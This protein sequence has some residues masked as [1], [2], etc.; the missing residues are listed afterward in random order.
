MELDPSIL[1]PVRD[2]QKYVRNI[3]AVRQ[4][5]TLDRAARH[6]LGDMV[7]A[8]DEAYRLANDAVRSEDPRIQRLS[9]VRALEHLEAF[10]AALLLASQ[11]DLVDTVDVAQFSAVAEQASD[12]LSAALTS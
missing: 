1:K 7:D 6:A 2:V 5:H 11:H 9:I 4:R 3:P 10:R 8:L 12:G